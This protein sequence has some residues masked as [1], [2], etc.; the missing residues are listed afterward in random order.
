MTSR[1]L[2]VFF[3]LL[4]SAP[5][6]AQTKTP[7]LAEPPPAPPQDPAPSA[8]QPATPAASTR[9]P[10]EYGVRFG[11]SFTSLESIQAIDVNVVAAAP[12][13][14]MNFGVFATVHLLGPLAVQPELLWA[15]KGQRIHHKDAKP[16]VSGSGTKAPE[17]DRVV[18]VRYLEIP[19]LMRV[20][21]VTR[22]G[23]SFF[24]I[25]GPA[26]SIRRNAV[27]RQV[28]DSGKLVD[29]TATVA[30]NDFSLV[31]GAGVQYQRWIADARFTKGRRNIAV[32]PP[33][34]LAVQPGVVK[35][36]AFAVL[37]G[38]RL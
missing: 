24:V 2:V 21:K 30:G 10:M 19:L 25:A 5:A 14:T 6:L 1:A 28:A 20:S 31:Y 3:L 18:L 26:V 27:I 9:R 38:V 29:I 7:A 11:P 34:Q 32:A 12:E 35:T 33:A 16:T 17:A 4:A 15:S 37:I 13:P 22:T 36:S 23:T 8:A